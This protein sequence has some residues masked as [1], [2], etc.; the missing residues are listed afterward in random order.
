[1]GR[2]CRVSS[3]RMVAKLPCSSFCHASYL[4]FTCSENRRSKLESECCRH[5]DQTNMAVL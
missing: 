3:A 2:T 4:R 1:M 5:I